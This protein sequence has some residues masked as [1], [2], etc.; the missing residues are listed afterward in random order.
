MS[1]QLKPK[2]N[3]PQADEER[4]LAIGGEQTPDAPLRVL[5]VAARPLNA[6]ELPEI[7]DA[8][9][10]TD[11][12]MSVDAP[13]EAHFIRPPTVKQLE[14]EIDG[15]C[16]ILHFD[17]HGTAE[18]GG[19]LDFEKED[20]LA[21]PLPAQM[22][23]EKLKN[24]GQPPRLLILS[25]CQ[26][27]KGEKDGL[28]G[29]IAREAKIPAV[30]GFS[31]TV[32]VNVTMDFVKRLYAALGTGRTVQEAFEAARA[33][34]G[35]AIVLLPPEKA[36]EP[37]R[38]IRAADLPVLTGKGI[39]QPLCKPQRGRPQVEREPLVGVPSPSESGRFHGVYDARTDPP[40]GR[41]ALLVE[42]AQS[43]LRGEKVVV[44]TGVGGIGKTALAAALARRLAWRF[45]GGVFWANGADYVESGMSLDDAL[46]PFAA[47]FGQDFLKFPAAQKRQAVL[48][49]FERMEAPALWVVDN[50]DV[51]AEE[52]WRMA[53][54]APGR[55]AVLLT[56]RERPE[57]GG[58]V[59]SVEGMAGEEALLF[60]SQET[61]RRKNQWLTFDKEAFRTFFE[62][63]GLLD[64]HALALMHAAALIADEGLDAALKAVRANPAR[65]ETGRR[66]DF[67]YGRL[68]VDEKRLLHRLAAFAADFDAQAVEVVCTAPLDERDK[69]LLPTWEEGLRS[70]AR[71]SFIEVHLWSDDYRRYRLHPV[72][73]E[74]VRGKGDRGIGDRGEWRMAQ[75]YLA[76]AD[77]AHGLLGDT[78][79]A[80]GAVQFAEIERINLLAGQ[81]ACLKQE[82]WEEAISFAYRLDDLFKRSGRW[83]FRRRS[84][85]MGLA[86]GKKA[87]G[88]EH[89]AM[90]HNLSMLAQATGDYAEARRL[91]QE[92]LKIAE[93]LGDKSGVS[94]SLHQLGMLAQATGDY[95]EARRLYQESLNIKEQLGDK[96]GVSRSLHQL[97]MLAQAT[98]DYAEA[99][100]LYQESLKILE[101]LGDK[102]GVASSKA[103]LSLL[104]EKEGNL[105]QALALITEAE[106]IFTALGAPQRK[107]ARQ[108]RERIE[109][110]L[111]RK[112]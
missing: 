38:E 54:Q 106:A 15:G 49:Y 68:T 107:E 16:D 104:E 60:L 9:A 36:G 33:S 66:F 50:A 108:D 80:L 39:K 77:A 57:Y 63:A 35:K 22:F 52:V 62:I 23:I 58:C 83:D 24:A 43:L 28:A 100:R 97:G 102:S 6:S 21:E 4:R 45:P 89:A 70:L 74:Y 3:A 7:A 53:R 78:E 91:Y 71:K 55:S 1:S 79:K 105:K 75:Y 67:S 101:Q 56:S 88:H 73:R 25:A 86:A 65:G 37:A 109:G 42:S 76:I 27:A 11:G 112:R 110:K 90:L 17:G 31:E 8:W 95:A 26:S 64:G 20:G 2:K 51:A 93:Q 84:L 92:S 82:R 10:L 61:M 87:G 34:L 46:S 44:L 103:Q 111:R 29:R 59:I 30:I 94:I 48:A 19:F 40:S 41:K 98:G 69:D 81:E 99:R 13:V 85:E 14:A 47:A 96:S 32:P 12:L 18:L 72:L 5:T